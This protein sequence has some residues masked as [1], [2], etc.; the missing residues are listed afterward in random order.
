MDPDAGYCFVV[1]LTSP[2]FPLLSLE[3]LLEG[4]VGAVFP[5]LLVVEQL[6]LVEKSNRGIDKAW[7]EQ[8]HVPLVVVVDKG[9]VLQTFVGSVKAESRF[10][11]GLF[12]H[13]LLLFLLL[14]LLQLLHEEL[15]VR[16]FMLLLLLLLC[17]LLEAKDIGIGERKAIGVEGCWLLLLVF[18]LVLEV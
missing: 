9:D 1:I 16:G 6:F 3:L 15:P 4:H 5:Q 14:L 11:I 7:R 13:L 8:L 10:W 17:L 18:V 12:I 2:S